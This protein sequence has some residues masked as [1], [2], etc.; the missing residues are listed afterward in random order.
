MV[1]DG[2][3][4]ALEREPC[5]FKERKKA[6]DLEYFMQRKTETSIVYVSQSTQ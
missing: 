6:N 3:F 4:T 2:F 5:H 1:R